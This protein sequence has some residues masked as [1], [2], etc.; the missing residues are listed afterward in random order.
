MNQ[1]NR[2]AADDKL[3]GTEG[4]VWYVSEPSGRVT[5]WKCKPESVEEIHWATGINKVA[6]IATCWNALEASDVLNLDV[7]RPLLLEEY[8]PG[9]PQRRRCRV[10]GP[11]AARDHISP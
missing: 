2:P 1:R 3:H 6:V 11:R 7:L 9:G 8:Q 4:A 5:M 10:T